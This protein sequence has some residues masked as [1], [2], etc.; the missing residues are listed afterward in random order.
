ML[1]LF[2]LNIYHILSY[3][4][5]DITN[6]KV[7]SGKNANCYNAILQCAS[8]VARESG[9]R[10]T[11]R[12]GCCSA[13][14]RSMLSTC[15][16]SHHAVAPLTETL[17]S[18]QDKAITCPS[19]SPPHMTAVCPD[20]TDKTANRGQIWATQKGLERTTCACSISILSS[21]FSN[22]QKPKV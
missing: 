9:L 12:S 15:A 7:H 22:V 10:L 11:R 2:L 5:N 13:I 19:I 17:K 20:Y 6:C 1:V 14:S 18:Q 3:R 8:Q 4:I 16:D 21:I